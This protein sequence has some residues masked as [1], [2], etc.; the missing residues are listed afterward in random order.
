MLE[1]VE[2]PGKL[3][4]A[5][6]TTLTEEQALRTSMHALAAVAKPIELISRG[7]RCKPWS[8]GH[9]K[10]FCVSSSEMQSVAWNRTKA[11]ER[12]LSALTCCVDVLADCGGM[13]LHYVNSKDVLITRL[14]ACIVGA[15]WIPACPYEVG[16]ICLVR[17]PSIYTHQD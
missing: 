9:L 5:G 16:P 7:A 6:R 1:V 3:E 13:V 4:C 11:L 2:K 15:P 12:V 14:R 17:T 8:G 10:V